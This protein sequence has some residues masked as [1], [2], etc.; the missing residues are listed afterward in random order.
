M[1]DIK[2]LYTYLW[3]KK[4]LIL[5]GAT[6]SGLFSIL[7]TLSL[8]NEYTAVVY[9]T[10]VKKDSETSLT[11]VSNESTFGFTIPGLGG[12]NGLTPE[13][14]KAVTMMKS[15]D[16]IDEFIRIHGLEVPL[17]AGT[18][19][20]EKSRTLIIDQKKYNLKDGKWVNS[21]FDINQP[22]VRWE[23]YKKFEEEMR[24][25][26]DK[27]T[28]VHQ[29]MVTSYSPDLALDWATKF[30]Q[31]LNSKMR[32]KKLETLNKNIENLQAQISLN[33]NAFLRDKLYDIQSRQ[34]NSKVMIEASPE[35][36]L[37]P[38]GDPISPYE[39]SFP[40]RTLLVLSLTFIGTLVSILLILVSR[41][42]QSQSE[43][44][45]SM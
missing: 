27:N 38:V 15:W 8:T 32:S 24:I 39:R 42:F 12:G 7:Y 2:D 41:I 34:I 28:G 45:A 5:I 44:I 17:L 37:E 3:R 11:Q 30:Y 36:V 9:L 19:W 26:G 16:F 31:L 20:D 6:L 13:M 14:N 21:N 43:E 18:G 35:Y 4:F 23:L 40:K 29:L 10:E 25:L 33:P 1:I 22:S